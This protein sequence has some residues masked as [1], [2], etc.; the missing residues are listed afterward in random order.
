MVVVYVV[1]IG[2]NGSRR[3][4]MMDDKFNLLEEADADSDLVRH[5]VRGLTPQ[6]VDPAGWKGAMSGLTSEESREAIF[7][8]VI[9]V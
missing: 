5:A 8:R 6:Q 4:L 3:A 1:M 2:R 9:F 7:Y